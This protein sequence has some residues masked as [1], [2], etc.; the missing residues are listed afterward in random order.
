MA[1]EEAQ[2]PDGDTFKILYL[3]SGKIAV[4]KSG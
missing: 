2:V 3:Y 4:N 1:C